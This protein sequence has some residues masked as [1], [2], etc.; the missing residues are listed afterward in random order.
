MN[1]KFG[2]FLLIISVA[3]LLSGCRDDNFI[4]PPDDNYLPDDY[5]G[6]SWSPDGKR[7]AYY[8]E[9]YE[10][11][12]TYP[13][14][15]YLIDT[16]GAN[17]VM[18]VPGFA[19]APHWSPDGAWIV[20]SNDGLIC[21]IKPNGDS[22]IDLVGGDFPR[23]SPDGENIAYGMSGTQDTVGLWM[24]DL[25]HGTKHRIGYGGDVDWSP[26]GTK[27][28]ST[29]G[30]STITTEGQIWIMDTSGN[31]RRQ[32]TTNSFRFN[33]YP[34]WSKD[35]TIITWSVLSN[36][37][38][39]VWLMHTD[40]SNQHKLTDGYYGSFSPDSRQLVISRVN[41]AKTNYDLWKINIDGSHPKQLT[42]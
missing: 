40:G 16:S 21:V 1:L 13:S 14:G 42:H 28:V 29:G 3:G 41:S 4:S 39:E 24:F 34:R 35:N 10:H 23:W 7:I 32:L 25:R 2:A 30:P 15:L 17:R 6:P 31:N 12:S 20:F 22:L 38:P 5:T 9:N 33:R 36:L 26:D 18:L 11:D 27:F 19:N 37:N 8:H